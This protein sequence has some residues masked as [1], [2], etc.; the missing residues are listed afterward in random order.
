MVDKIGAIRDAGEIPLRKVGDP[1]PGGQG[2]RRDRQGAARGRTSRSRSSACRG[3]SLSRRCSTSCSLLEVVDDATANPAMLR[4]AHRR[5]A[6]TSVRATSRC[7]ADGRPSWPGGRATTTSDT[8]TA[9]RARE[10]GR[11]H[12]PDRDR[13][14]RRCAG[15]PG[16][17]AVLR[18]GA[19]AIR[20]PVARSS[21]SVRRARERAAARPR[22]SRR[23][24]ARPRHRAGGR[25]RRG[26]RRQSRPACSTR[27]PSYAETDRYASLSGLLGYL[28]AEEEFNAG[29]EVSTPSRGR[30]R[31]AAHHPPGQGAGMA[32][33][34]RPAHVG[35][36]VPVRSR[37]RQL[38][39]HHARRCPPRCGEI[40][41]ACPFCR[42]GPRTCASRAD[43][44]SDRRR[45]A[46]GGASPRPTSPTPGAPSG[47]CCR[48]HWWG[49]TQQKPLG[50]SEF[51]LR[52]AEWLAGRASSRPSGPIRPSRR[53]DEPPSRRVRMASV[54]GRAAAFDR[55]PP[56]P[57]RRR[58]CGS[59]SGGLARCRR[60]RRLPRTSSST[61][62]S[63]TSSCCLA[64]AD[65]ERRDRASCRGPR[66]M[67]ATSVLDAAKDP[68]IRPRSWPG[69]CRG[70]RRRRRASAPGSTPGSRRTTADRSCSTHRPPGPRRRR[71]R[72]ATPSSTG[73]GD[74]P[75][76]G[77]YGDRTPAA[78]EAPFSIV[79]GGQQVIGRIDA[80]FVRDAD[81]TGVRGRRLEDQPGRPPT[82]C[83]SPSTGWRGPR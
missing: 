60:A 81:G 10:G 61:G 30:V 32:H 48:G 11:G 31:Q 4:L 49:R 76:S 55:R 51:L 47:W 70:S 44:P 62:S 77:P 26:R 27:S 3:C 9:V 38:V 18:R 23:P 21:R 74:V 7:S 52:H 80:V 65:A 25:R 71:P 35:H 63:R 36:G 13:V 68:Q 37:P 45:R 64:E 43:A 75:G 72:L 28:A 73:Q 8:A 82:R 12:R 20:R 24:R 15:R 2:E 5:R 58:P 79:L 17:P 83:S 34:L 56:R 46:D 39:D 14:A 78:I 53:R 42:S 29:M 6:G 16:R 54:A 22:P 1:G 19:R 33:G 59:S 41:T 69:R 50:P 67:S 66:R 57:G 40:A